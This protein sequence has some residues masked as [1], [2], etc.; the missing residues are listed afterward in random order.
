MKSAVQLRLHFIGL[1]AALLSF[2]FAGSAFSAEDPAAVRVASERDF[3]PYSFVDAQGRPAGFGVDL[4]RA[5]A[6]SMDIPIEIH[7]ATWDSA[8]NGLVEGS[9]D[10][11]PI[12]A[13]L[14]SREPL[15]D[16]SLPHTETFDSF[17]VRDGDPLIRDIAG[18]EGKEVIV[19]RSD[20]A[21]HIL[22]ERGFR[23]KIIPVDTISEM[24]YLLAS[25]K[26]DALLYP[27]L[28]GL[29]MIRD[30]K[31][32]GVA[33]GPTIPDY[34]REF[35]FAVKK[36]D[37][38]LLEKLNQGLLIVKSNGEYERIYKKWFG[39]EDPWRRYVEFFWPVMVI[40]AVVALAASLSA[41]MLRR[42]V[43]RRTVELAEK[44]RLLSLAREEL[45]DRV[46]QRT[47]ELLKANA[48][49]T[50]E[51]AERRLAEATLRDSEERYRSH[52]EVTGQIGW[53]TDAGGNVVDDIPAWRRYTGQT[54][55]E[56]K[57]AGWARAVHPDD[58]SRTLDKW[59]QSINEGGFF[60]TEYRVRRFDGAYRHFLARG[61]PLFREDGRIRE[62]VGTCIDITERKQSEDLLRKAHE[63]LETRIIERTAELKAANA[64]LKQEIAE[65]ERMEDELIKAQKLESLGVFAGGIAHDFN[66][67]LQS[68]TNNIG[69]ARLYASEKDSVEDAL[70]DAETAAKYASQ[71]SQ[72]LLTFA[73]GGSPVKKATPVSRLIEES[74]CISLSGS[75]ILTECEVPDGLSPVEVDE[76]QINQVLN[77]LLINAKEAMPLG[78]KIRIRA[79][80]VKAGESDNLFLNEGDYVRISVEDQGAGIPGENLLRIFDPYFSTKERGAEK[81]TGLG[82]SV[83]HSILMKH[84]GLISVD[85][86]AGV[87]STFHVFLPVSKEPL[88]EAED[89]AAGPVASGGR[90]LFME[91]ERTMWKSAGLLL[92]TMGL[93]VEFTMNGA[94]ALSLYE[95]A[96]GDGRPFDGV[97]LDLT[98][99]GGMGGKET[100]A[101]LREIDRS[102]K[103]IV[104]S[105]YTD[106]PVMTNFREYGFVR[107]LAK[108]YTVEQLN[109]AVREEF[110]GARPQSA[111]LS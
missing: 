106:D 21:H 54:M 16:F 68:I 4:I 71:L 12:V 44:N 24:L 76:G 51:N 50:S 49:L 110:G 52:I 47:A 27:K 25:G 59:Q 93:D 79:E 103:A 45:S 1:F 62:W 67:L 41:V 5:V 60:E 13:K 95:K 20:A 105:G 83:C 2:L 31:V 35:S 11:L 104:V 73:K 57:G 40:S 3:K 14:S 108:P 72:R 64:R 109:N 111:G 58:V 22:L 101:R 74:V 56:I 17:F 30:L 69:V 18:A 19:M 90:I 77:N 61:I 46:V 32:T 94:E 37:T 43:K 100:I 96:L 29:I 9:F 15:V 80:G 92:K 39:F 75:N 6:D 97:I 26:H 66:N 42:M 82:L 87:G 33:A 98:I 48:A 89:K 38:E 34:K 85:S 99:P 28:L 78:G 86:K 53:S 65:R 70:G 8:W 7:P 91:D 10:A 36:G 23:G 88:P 55:D 84:G 102:V 63:E 107:A 81:G